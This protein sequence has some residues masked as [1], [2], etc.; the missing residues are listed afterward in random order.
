MSKGWRHWA[1][2]ACP[3]L[4][5]VTV[6]ASA[7]EEIRP[8]W[9]KFDATA[10]TVHLRLVGAADGS[11]GTMNFNGYGS[12]SMTITVPLG[13]KVDVDFTNKGLAALPHSLVVINEVTPLPIE[14]GAPA[15]SKALTV[16]LIPGM[17]AGKGDTFEFVANKAGRFLLFCGVTGHGVAGMWDYLVVSP[18]VTVPS[19]HVK[20]KK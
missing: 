20:A 4:V 9:M 6:V 13:W 19:V 10:R 2:G 5:A 1:A 8:D 15:F 17:D 12:G 18:D 3:A 7:D 11:N 14:G 16:R